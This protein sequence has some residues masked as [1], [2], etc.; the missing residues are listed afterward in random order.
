[1]TRKDYIRIAESLDFAKGDLDNSSE[2]NGYYVAVRAI[3]DAL[4]SDNSAFDES[5]FFAVVN[6][7][8]FATPS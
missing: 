2:T 4:K 6:A 3:A 8:S 7:H 5:R 1:M